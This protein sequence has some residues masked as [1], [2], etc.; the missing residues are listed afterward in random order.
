MILLSKIPRLFAL[1]IAICSCLPDYAQTRDGYEDAIYRYDA[2]LKLAEKAGDSL[3]VSYTLSNIAGILVIQKKFDEAELYL[4]RCLHIRD[5]LKDSF[6]I[7]LAYS[8]LGTAMS[9]I[10]RAHV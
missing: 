1:F 3:S 8:D 5:Q 7:A 2:S 4:L 6:A 9:E 10:G